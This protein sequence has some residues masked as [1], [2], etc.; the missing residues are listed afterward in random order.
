MISCLVTWAA[1]G[2]EKYGNF[3][4]VV[5]VLGIFFISAFVIVAQTCVAIMS[6]MKSPTFEVNGEGELTKANKNVSNSIIL[7]VVIAVVY[8]LVSMIF[9]YLPILK[10]GIRGVYLIL[11]GL[12][13]LIA[14]VCVLVMFLTL[15]KRYAKI[16]P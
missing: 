6:D 10:T 14:G 16:V 8:G 3:M 15:D 12:S 2:G 1:F 9:T 7:G 11:N 4:G 5:D 13:L